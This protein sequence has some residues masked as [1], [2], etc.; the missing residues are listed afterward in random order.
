MSGHT[1]ATTIKDKEAMSLKESKETLW[2]GFGGRGRKGKLC[3]SI[4]TSK[5]LSFKHENQSN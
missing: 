5:H 4:I 3:H 1:D 2:K